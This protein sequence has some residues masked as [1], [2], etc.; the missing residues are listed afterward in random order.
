MSNVLYLCPTPI[1]N[2]SDMTFRAVECLKAADLIAAEDTRHTR[3]L[4]AHFEI[5]KELVRYDEHN[6]ETAGPW[7]IEKLQQG[8][9]IALVSD[10]G[11]PGISDPGSDLVR[12]AIAAGIAVVPLPGANAAL[13]ALIASGLDTRAFTFLGFLP[14]TKKK[15]IE[16]LNSLQAHPYSLLFYES[17]HHLLTTLAVLR[18]VLGDRPAVAG[19]ELT[20]KFEE[21]VRGTLSELIEHFTQQPPRGEFSLVVSGCE[22]EIVTEL[23]V[24]DEAGLA[25]A[26]ASLTAEGL[27]PKE[28]MRQV[29]AKYDLTKREVYQAVLACKD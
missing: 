28:A 15:Q 6:K 25:A 2:L 11:M 5:H 21:F 12:L 18:E 16:L 7:L 8:Q 4:L 1:G 27:A 14:K 13:C 29:A 26:V 23:V 10:A 24:P 17:P 3:K 20:K 9:S 19:R 22:Q